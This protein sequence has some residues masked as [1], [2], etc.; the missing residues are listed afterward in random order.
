MPPLCP[1]SGIKR[2]LLASSNTQ[3]ML[4][5]W[6]HTTYRP[7]GVTVTAPT[8]SDALIVCSSAIFSRS[9]SLIWRRSDAETANLPSAVIQNARTNELCPLRI[10]GVRF[11]ARSHTLSVPSPD[12]EI[13]RLLSGVIATARTVAVWPSSVASSHSLF[14]SQTLSVWSTEAETARRPSAVTAMDQTIAPWPYSVAIQ[15]SS[16]PSGG[17]AI[18]SLPV[19]C[20]GPDYSKPKCP[21]EARLEVF[22]DHSPRCKHSCRLTLR[23]TGRNERVETNGVP[24]ADPRP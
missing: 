10:V 22:I 2:V 6:L 12:P 16:S 21:S 7:F 8:S 11:R 15:R 1:F 5:P 23:S 24:A 19:R 3:S 4:S 17:L 9:Q 20:R 14:T 18:I 13:A